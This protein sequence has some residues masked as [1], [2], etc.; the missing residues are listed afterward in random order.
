MSRRRRQS[1]PIHAAP[2]PASRTSRALK[3]LA[4]SLTITRP[5]ASPCIR[6]TQRPARRGIRRN[7]MAKMR[8]ERIA[9]RDGTR[10]RSRGEGSMQARPAPSLQVNPSS[11]HPRFIQRTGSNLGRS[12]YVTDR[13]TT[14]IAAN[15]FK[16]PYR[17]SDA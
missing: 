17:W 14:E 15:P 6:I 3:S 9:R 7:R 1:D 5:V 4:P 12:P 11:T 2:P 8:E 13:D 10:V 16:G